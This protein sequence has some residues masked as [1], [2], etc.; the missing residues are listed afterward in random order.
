MRTAEGREALHE[1]MRDE[2][3]AGLTESDMRQAIQATGSNQRTPTATPG[4][5]NNSDGLRRQV[6][7]ARQNG[8]KSSQVDEM[9]REAGAAGWKETYPGYSGDT[10]FRSMGTRGTGALRDRF[11]R[12]TADRDG[13]GL[14][15]DDGNK[16]VEY[17]FSNV[18]DA[19][20]S[21][22]RFVS[23][24]RASTKRGGPKDNEFIVGSGRRR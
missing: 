19:V 3:E 18:S 9:V 8:Y 17:R 14:Y 24:R 5:I 11:V 15:V 13:V 16:A 23:N 4:L 20:A 2:R 6:Q 22:N 7:E 12:V 1:F 21:G 10:A